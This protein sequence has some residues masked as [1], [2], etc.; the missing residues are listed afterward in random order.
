MHRY[1]IAMIAACLVAASPV[2]ARAETA[3]SAYM[4]IQ[5]AIGDASI[6]DQPES[7]SPTTLVARVGKYYRSHYSLEGRLAIPLQDDTATT[8]AGDTTVGLFGI[9][10]AYGTARMTLLKRY[11]LYGIAGFSAVSWEVEVAS[12]ERSDTDVGFSYGAGIGIGFGRSALN[13]EYLSY[14]DE[15]E[16]DLDA[17]SLGLTITF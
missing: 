6:D 2:T 14:L 16:F 15:T 4:G 8:S 13:I 17:F 5:Y 3:S 10:G 9:F 11:S 12:V 1:L 7:F